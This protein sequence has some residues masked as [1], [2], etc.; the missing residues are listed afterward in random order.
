M[1]HLRSRSAVVQFKIASWVFVM[2]WLLLGAGC[3]GLVLAAA[4]I[5]RNVMQLAVGLLGVGFLLSVVHWLQSATARCPLCLATPMVHRSCS[6]HRRAQRL[7]GSYRLRVALGVLS[8]RRFR[9][10]YCGE[11]TL[12]QTRSTSDC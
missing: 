9:C 8:S 12:V 5:N 10:P 3:L 4:A 11:I 1:Y 6:K 7:F 2:K